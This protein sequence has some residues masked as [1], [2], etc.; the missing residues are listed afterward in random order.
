MSKGTNHEVQCIGA[1]GVT[2]KIFP[3]RILY[4]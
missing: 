3:R 2:F 4:A 1:G